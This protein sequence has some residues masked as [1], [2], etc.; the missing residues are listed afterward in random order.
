M[1]TVVIADDE[2]I[3]HEGVKTTIQATLPE[4]NVMNVFEDGTTL[5]DY[6]DTHQPDI[7]LLDIEM[8]GKSG[9]DIA[10][11]ITKQEYKCYIIIITAHHNFEY[12][13]KAIDYGVGAF[14][15][16]PF[17]SQQL[18][19]ALKKAISF[20]NKEHITF[21]QNRSAY[22]TILQSLCMSK[23]NLLF[24]ESI[25]LCHDTT[26]LNKLKC[27]EVL[28][29]HDAINTLDD[30]DK[31]SLSQTLIN[32][33]EYDNSEQSVFFLGNTQDQIIFLIFSKEDPD[34]YFVTDVINIIKRYI[35]TIPQYS[36]S[37]HSSFSEYRIHLS[38]VR[39]MD[40][41]FSILATHGS[42]QAKKQLTEYVYSLSASQSHNFALFLANGYLSSFEISP[43]SQEKHCAEMI[44]QNIDDLINLTLGNHSGNYI[45]DSAKEYI[46]QNYS[47]CALS[48]D[49]T[50]DALSISANYLGRIFK[51]YTGNNFSEYLQ[52]Y[53]MQQAQ[54]LLKTTHMPTIDV[55]NAVGY[56]NPVYF[57]IS[58]KSHFGMTPT[59]FR[60]IQIKKE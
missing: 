20:I 16:K 21:T 30:L 26:L 57:R 49:A 36:E 46:H 19:D 32:H 5:Y 41:F 60:Q 55:A 43:S 40:A 17:S 9:L 13:K 28:F 27:T 35:G 1:Y 39:E 24:N 52:N 25:Y 53:R 11:H 12:A 59:Q 22:R 6:L 56:S 51:K 10:Y 29:K 34:L 47:S 37:R 8:P 31:T 58:F 2:Q 50:A 7:L 38:F 54:N 3:I 33:I 44:V 23:T 18:V 42:S 15:T 45:V 48:L 4:L 14:L